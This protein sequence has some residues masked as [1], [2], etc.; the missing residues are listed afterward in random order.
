MSVGGV[1]CC[2][3]VWVEFHQCSHGFKQKRKEATKHNQCDW[4][5]SNL[6]VLKVI[7]A[8][9]GVALADLSQRLVLVTAHLHVLLVQDV[10]L[11]HLAVVLVQRQVF[12]QLLKGVKRVPKLEH[13]KQG[14]T[15]D[16]R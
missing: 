6:H 13:C 15:L 2:K 4:L 14:K 9:H 1:R 10:V 12:A 8:T 11:C 3:G 16:R 5:W 7:N